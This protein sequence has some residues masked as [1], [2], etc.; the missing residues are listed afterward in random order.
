MDAE[1]TL[2]DAAC[3]LL[4][5]AQR[6]VQAA[7][8]PEVDRAVPATIGCIEASL[9][10]LSDACGALTH[11]SAPGPVDDASLA[12]LAAALRRAQVA[13]AIARSSRRRVPAASGLRRWSHAP[14]AHDVG[15]SDDV[16]HAN[17]LGLPPHP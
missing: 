8:H 16:S 2:Y 7:A 15:Q 9:A 1:S 13:A 12:E 5:A 10:S 14:M 4:D 3:D 6:L 11:P 17:D